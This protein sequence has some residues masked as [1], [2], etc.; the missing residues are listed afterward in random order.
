[1]K[2]R[3]CWPRSRVIYPLVLDLAQARQNVQVQ[4]RVAIVGAYVVNATVTPIVSLQDPA[5][6]T[7][8]FP[9][10]L[11]VVIQSPVQVVYVTNAVGSGTLYLLM[12]DDPCDSIAVGSS[13]SGGTNYGGDNYDVDLLWPPL[14]NT[15]AKAGAFDQNA[16]ARQ[17]VPN[18]IAA[19]FSSNYGVGASSM[20]TFLGATSST[21]CGLLTGPK[22]YWMDGFPVYLEPTIPAGVSP[23]F[24]FGS[25]RRVWRFSCLWRQAVGVPGLVTGIGFGFIAALAAAGWDTASIVLCGNGGGG[26]QIRGYQAAAGVPT[27]TVPLSWPYAV[28]VPVNLEWVVYNSSGTLPARIELWLNGSLVFRRDWSMTGMPLPAH[29]GGG[30]QANKMIFGFNAGAAGQTS[31]FTDVRCRAGRF[32]RFGAEIG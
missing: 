31:V 6:N 27:F 3:P 10:T 16:M 26:M 11:P 4:G 17:G 32:D 30:V 13:G 1:M 22:S 21:M 5:G 12:S 28:T 23:D 29:A 15:I 19:L 24:T 25:A 20:D 2:R 8:S 14:K 7:R 9:V 18:A